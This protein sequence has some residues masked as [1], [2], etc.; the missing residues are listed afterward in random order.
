[1]VLRNKSVLAKPTG[2]FHKV[3]VRPT[4]LYG[5]DYWHVKN[6]HI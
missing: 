2:K 3:V 6:S 5:V 1:M 4:M